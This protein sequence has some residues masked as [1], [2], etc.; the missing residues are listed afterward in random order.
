[1]YRAKPLNYNLSIYDLEFLG[2]WTYKGALKIDLDIKKAAKEIVL[3]AN[4]LVLQSAELFTDHPKTQEGLKSSGI[5][6]DKTNQRITISFAQQFP[7]SKGFLEIK[8][9]GV[10]N[11]VILSYLI[12]I[13]L[14]SSS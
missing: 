13:V 5:D 3:N 9:Q 14:T 10:M 2:N 6:Y 12:M 8:F 1:L 4:Q 11:N 7:V